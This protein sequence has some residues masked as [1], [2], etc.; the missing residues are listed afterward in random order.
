MESQGVGKTVTFCFCI[1]CRLHGSEVKAF[2]RGKYSCTD[3]IR[4]KKNERVCMHS[5]RATGGPLAGHGP[6][7]GHWRT[8]G[9]PL[10][11]HWLTIGRP[12]LVQW[13]GL[14]SLFPLSLLPALRPPR[15]RRVFSLQRCYIPGLAPHVFYA[16]RHSHARKT[17]QNDA[18]LFL[19]TF[20]CSL[21]LYYTYYRKGQK[22]RLGCP[23]KK[24][25]LYFLPLYSTGKIIESCPRHNKKLCPAFIFFLTSS[26]C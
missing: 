22:M 20:T 13:Q 4:N 26:L 24:R 16:F 3:A 5:W 23:K 12:L 7:T 8:T 6:L 2:L 17:K 21:Y 19:P 9:G 15:S 18:P 14:A 10:T 1:V 25:C 11:G